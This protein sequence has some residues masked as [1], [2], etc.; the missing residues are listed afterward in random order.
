LASILF[1]INHHLYQGKGPAMFLILAIPLV[2][3]LAVVII[4]N[5]FVRKRNLVQEAWSGIDV[6]LKRRYDLIPNL[7]RSVQGYAKHEKGLFE[8]VT[9]ARTRAIEA[10]GVKPQAEAENT[11]TGQIRSL[12]AVAENYPTLKANENFISLQNSLN[13]IEDQI[14]MA[15]RYYNGTVRDFNILVQSFP[16]NLIAGIFDFKQKEFFEIELA[17]QRE[18]PEVKF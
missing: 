14:Q 13:E 15:R 5:S 12:F 4:Y 1:I 7:V 8:S 16:S 2:L 9:N 3:I 10:Q 11:L 6:Q 18:T 17:T